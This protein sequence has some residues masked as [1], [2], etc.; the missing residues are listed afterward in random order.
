METVIL[1]DE[2]DREL[3]TQE[4]LITH[5]M[6]QLHRAVSV[7]LFN[8]K[9]QILLQKRALSKYHS[10]GLWSNTCCSH[11]RPGEDSLHAAERRLNEELGIKRPL[12]KKFHFI[13]KANLDSGLQEHELDH[14]FYGTFD[15]IPHPDPQEV[16]DWKWISLQELQQEIAAHPERYTVWF[17]ILLPKL[18]Q[19]LSLVC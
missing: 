4:K 7:V 11:P 9:N 1:V 3:G 2:N 15:G 19:N 13:Y 10:G 6:G 16:S 8:G 14:V 18:L 12:Q 17:T 5:K